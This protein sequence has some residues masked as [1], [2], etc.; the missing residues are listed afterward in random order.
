MSSDLNPSS[1]GASQPLPINPYAASDEPAR[2]LSSSGGE[3]ATPRQYRIRMDWA[4]RRR[5]MRTAG[6][7]RLWAVAGAVMGGY[8]MFTMIQGL[9]EASR[10]GGSLSSVGPYNALH[11]VLAVVRG[12]ILLVQC[13][14]YWKLAG[15]MVATAGGST[16]SM[17]EWSLHQWNMAR[18][19]VASLVLTVLIEGWDR[20]FLY[21]LEKGVISSPL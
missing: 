15:A 20:L 19:L 2:R 1:P 7:F 10:I 11:L 21:L 6:I 18:I 3:T 8:A 12:G 16:G 4:D 5:F 14:L 17:R 9:V 13:Y